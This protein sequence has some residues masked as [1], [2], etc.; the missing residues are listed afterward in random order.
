MK[1]FLLFLVGF[2]LFHACCCWS[3]SF[4]AKPALRAHFAS[5]GD[6]TA[7]IACVYGQL[8]YRFSGSRRGMGLRRFLFA[9]RGIALSV[10]CAGLRILRL[11][12][13]MA[14]DFRNS[15][16]AYKLSQDLPQSA[17]TYQQ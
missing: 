2:S 14:G 3:G 7:S 11:S 9:S 5:T 16:T 17:A 15:L 10:V 4:T 1:V 12:A 8:L 6:W 13:G